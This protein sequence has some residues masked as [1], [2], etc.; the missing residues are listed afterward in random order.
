MMVKKV[1][2]NIIFQLYKQYYLPA[3]EI[4]DYNVNIDG[5]N[6]CDQPINNDL[7]TYFYKD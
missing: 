2:S 1:T 4:K 3:V 5:R 6:F 7:K